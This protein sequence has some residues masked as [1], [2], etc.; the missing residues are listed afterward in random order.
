MYWYNAPESPLA[1]Y[2]NM[3]IYGF[4]SMQEFWLDIIIFNIYFFYMITY[5]LAASRDSRQTFH[6]DAK[7]PE[8]SF[9]VFAVAFIFRY[10]YLLTILGLFFMGFSV[11]NVINLIYVIMFLVFFSS[12]ENILVDKKTV[13]G[14]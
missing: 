10:T 5:L 3:E 14:K 12:G 2:S 8:L 4:F 1:V 11:V 13:A 6:Q 9:W 7:K